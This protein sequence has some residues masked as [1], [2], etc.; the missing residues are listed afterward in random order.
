MRDDP[1]PDH[2]FAHPCV[3]EVLVPTDG[4]QWEWETLIE[5]PNLRR[6]LAQY[7]QA[8]IDWPDHEPRLRFPRTNF[9]ASRSE[10]I[11]LAA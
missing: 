5:S 11:A 4:D 6:L 1:I 2:N 10:L 8:R 7:A 9:I 3:V